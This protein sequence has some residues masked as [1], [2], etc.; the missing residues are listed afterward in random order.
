MAITLPEILK[1]T[2][3]YADDLMVDF[4]GEKVPLG[5]LRQFSA[6][7]LTAIAKR[8]QEAD[9]NF[10]EA[11]KARETAMDLSTKAQQLYD[12]LQSSKQ[13]APP[14]NTGDDPWETDP[15]Y[16]P[17]R[18]RSK[19]QEATIDE[20][21]KTLKSLQQT[22]EQIALIGGYDR[23]ER[24]FNSFPADRRP[25]DKSLDDVIKYAAE[26]KLV[27]RFGVPSVSMALDKLTEADRL[28][29]IRAKAR[30]EG[31]D[32]AEARL[33]ASTMPRPNFN[34]P[35]NAGKRTEVLDDL[36]HLTDKVLE[37]PELRQM[38]AGLN[39]S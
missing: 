24:Q 21:K 13:Q 18:T 4:A 19:A 7:E 30:K 6:G 36:D 15:I 32:E 29:D 1:D 2:T 10:A 5:S 22:Q 38:V 34:P 39:L 20:L 26:N 35:P 25:K 11:A 14:A 12:S 37:D 27:D 3:K 31:A 8:Q 28:D 16:A 17:V 23:W 33:R 9:R